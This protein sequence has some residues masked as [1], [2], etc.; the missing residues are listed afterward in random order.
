MT[1]DGIATE[2]WDQVHE[3]ALAVVNLSGEGDVAASHRA[4]LCLAELLDDLQEKY[5]PLPSLFATRADYL[6]KF[7]DRGY[8]HLAAYK[9]AVERGDA[10]NPASISESLAPLY[11]ESLRWKEA[12]GRMRRLEHDLAVCPDVY[13]AEQVVRIR[14]LRAS[15]AEAD[16][17]ASE[18]RA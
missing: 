2:D 15:H 11:V 3:L 1:S 13:E 18:E 9:Q 6:D 12:A 8:W 7:E 4:P 14:G 5:G 17:R 10:K 16:R